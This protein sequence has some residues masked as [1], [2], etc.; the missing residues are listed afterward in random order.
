MLFDAIGL[1]YDFDPVPSRTQNARAMRISRRFTRSAWTLAAVLFALA[2]PLS[3]LAHGVLVAHRFCAEHLVIEDAHADER[4]EQRQAPHG[5]DE[6]GPAR[7][8][9]H[10]ACALLSLRSPAPGLT[11]PWGER[12]PDRW[13]HAHDVCPSY[14]PP[15]SRSALLLVAPKTSPPSA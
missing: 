2:A 8:D 14:A 15:T 7:G 3:Q 6:N 5:D 1:R 10:E 9:S 11:V 4:A 13:V 12:D